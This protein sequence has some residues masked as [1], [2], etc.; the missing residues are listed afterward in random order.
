MDSTHRHIII[1]QPI[2]TYI[3]QL[4]MDTGCPLEELQRVMANRDGWRERVK[5]I[6]A[7][8]DDHHF[9]AQLYGIKYSY[10]IPIIFKQTYLTHRWN[11]KQIQTLQK[12]REDPEI[13]AMKFHIPQ[14]SRNG[15]SPLD[16][17]SCH[18]QYTIQIR[19]HDF[20]LDFHKTFRNCWSHAWK[21]FKL[22]SIKLIFNPSKWNCLCQ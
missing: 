21:A 14:S 15:A 5:R 19:L 18:T 8:F 12:I 17:V 9:F 3:H 11:S 7:C 13:M 22:Y 1:G 10:L 20:C 16:A 6:Y 4:C 2:K